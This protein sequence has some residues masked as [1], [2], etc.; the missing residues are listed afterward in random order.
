MIRT[1]QGIDVHKFDDSRPLVLGGVELDTRNGLA[2]HSDADVILHAITDALLGSVAAGDIGSYFPST[3]KEWENASSALFARAAL[4]EVEERGG[5][6]V[7]VDVTYLGNKPR[8]SEV[9]DRIRE[10]IAEILNVVVDR[11][12]VK[13]TTTD[14]LGLTGRGEGACAMAVVT[15]ELENE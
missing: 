15:V 9:R 1:G 5:R 3:S 13:A 14:G 4:A 6:V 2:G 12:S 7:S 11:V 8:V 10:S